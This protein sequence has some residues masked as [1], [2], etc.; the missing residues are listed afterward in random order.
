MEVTGAAA[1]EGDWVGGVGDQGSDLVDRPNP[2]RVTPGDA[3]RDAFRWSGQCLACL[4]V[5][6]IGQD[7]VTMD[8]VVAAPFQFGS[9][10]RFSRAGTAFD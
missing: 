1:E 7:P 10:R 3:V 8:D 4:G 5:A 6:D 2:V 9:D